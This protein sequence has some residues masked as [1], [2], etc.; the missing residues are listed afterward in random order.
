[1]LNIVEQNSS[2]PRAKQDVQKVSSS[3]AFK[4]PSPPLSKGEWGDFARGAY[5]GVR[6]HDKGPR[7]PLAAFFNILQIIEGLPWT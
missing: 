5:A 6:E 4:S 2:P 7:T 3:K 1:M